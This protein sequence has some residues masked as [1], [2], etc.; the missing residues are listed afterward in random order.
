MLAGAGPLSAL[1]TVIKTRKRTEGA[2][3]ETV[4]RVQR[5]EETRDRGRGKE[6]GAGRRN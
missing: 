2:K 1:D 3:K 4:N 5:A 6:K